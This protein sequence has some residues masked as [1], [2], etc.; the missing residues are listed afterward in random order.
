MKLVAET[1]KGPEAQTV[2]IGCSIEWLE[3]VA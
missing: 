3:D 1:G 2:S